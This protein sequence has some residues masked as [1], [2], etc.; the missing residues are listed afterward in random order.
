[1]IIPAHMNFFKIEECGLYKNGDQTAKALDSAETF[2]L[3]HQWVQGKPMEDTIPWDPSSGRSGD[4]KCY[5]HDFYKCEETG[6]FLFVLWKSD[7]TSAGSIFGAQAAEKT[8]SSNVIEYTNDY[9]GKPLIWGRPCYYWIVPKLNTVISIKLDHSVCDSTLFQEW[10][11]KCIQNRVSHANKK[12]TETDT[13]QIRFEFIDENDNAGSRYAFRFDVRLRSVDTGSAQLQELASRIT[14]IVRRD[15]IKLN[16][17][18][19]ERPN[20]VKLFD[21]VPLL[22]PKPNTKTRQIEIRA[23]AKPTAND[24]KNIIEKFAKDNRTRSDWNNI[25]FE[26]D[27]SVVW[28]D[29]YRLHETVNF[30]K[31]KSTTFAASE[32][33]SQLE[34]HRQRVLASVVADELAKSK[35]EKR[36]LKG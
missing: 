8:G 5:C 21:N 16:N 31:D 23:E 20:W 1:M 36:S 26:T 30:S 27:K 7:S 2:D 25:G 15:T 9:K 22:A 14:H 32:I 34:K 10:V 33:Y 3:I 18:I 19:D 24:L 4:A 11:T 12:K 29:S 6:D 28:V 13:G 17:G 35:M